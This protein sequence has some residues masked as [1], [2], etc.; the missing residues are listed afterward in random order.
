MQMLNNSEMQSTD[1][2]PGKSCNIQELKASL[3]LATNKSLT[4]RL[5]KSQSTEDVIHI[6]ER[7]RIQYS[8]KENL[9]EFRTEELPEKINYYGKVTCSRECSVLLTT[10]INLSYPKT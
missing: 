7:V 2:I 8:P 9:I 4:R 6:L 1:K 3:K 10:S 5:E